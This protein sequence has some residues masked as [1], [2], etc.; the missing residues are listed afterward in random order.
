M[1]IIVFSIIFIYSSS[2]FSGTCE[3]DPFGNKTLFN[4]SLSHQKTQVQGG[5]GTCY[6]NALSVAL[7]AEYGKNISYQQLALVGSSHRAKNIKS[8][9][10][11]D[12]GKSEMFVE[13][14]D[15]CDTFI[16][17]KKSKQKLCRSK[18]FPLEN[19]P[20]PK[21]QGETFEVIGRLY[22]R[23]Y[24]LPKGERIKFAQALQEKSMEASSLNLFCQNDDDYKVK[25]FE[26]EKTLRGACI[27][28]SAILNRYSRLS[29]TE[30][31]RKI[32][33]DQTGKNNADD[34]IK[35]KDAIGSMKENNKTSEI[36][37]VYKA[38][39]KKE[40]EKIKKDIHKNAGNEFNFIDRSKSYLKKLSPL[41]S[42]IIPVSDSMMGVK[43]DEFQLYMQNKIL[44]DLENARNAK[45]CKESSV[46]MDLYSLLEDDRC[47][48]GGFNQKE[49]E[50]AGYG[51]LGLLDLGMDIDEINSLLASFND[52]LSPQNYFMTTLGGNCHK[53]GLKFKDKLKCIEVGFPS[54][55]PLVHS[56][57]ELKK[58]SMKKL[59]DLYNNRVLKNKKPIV[60]SFCSGFLRKNEKEEANFSGSSGKKFKC[61]TT[62]KHGLHSVSIVGHRCINGKMEYEIL[63][64]WGAQCGSYNDFFKSKCDPETGRLFIP[65]EMLISNTFELEYLK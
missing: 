15:S 30:K 27:N 20:R 9:V 2:I 16:A 61:D 25:S 43:P 60:V 39:V 4:S 3:G 36:D 12:V 49:V 17:I 26:F 56:V 47:H 38:E 62:K 53:K 22:Q 35:L 33:L 23:L 1:K 10:K 6:A 54:G 18:D 14:G 13:G 19:L 52:Y 28:T 63:N 5:L 34:F 48:Y 42:K 40:I 41:I 57:E 46:V 32:F 37:C 64:S 11:G 58:K 55:N 44:E 29:K 59:D 7:G 50:G 21:Q 51:M 24:S 45:M 8:I 31:G 65:E